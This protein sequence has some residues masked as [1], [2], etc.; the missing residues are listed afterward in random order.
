[1]TFNC[2]ITVRG[3]ELDSFGHVNNA[4]YLNY[5][6]Q[7]RWEILKHLDLF[8]YFEKNRLVLVVAEATVRYSKEA[9]NFD[10]LEVRTDI[11]REAPYLVF[12]HVIKNKADQEVVAK[13]TIKTLLVDHERIPHDIP[14]FFMSGPQR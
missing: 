10:E 4:V 6:E 11:K 1:M 13:G 8:D 9:K 2:T 14:D 3:Y 5:F 12:T 7:A